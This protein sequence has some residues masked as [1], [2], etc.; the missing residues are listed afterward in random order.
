MSENDMYADDT[1]YK[2]C[3]KCGEEIRG[4]WASRD[5]KYWHP[6]C[7]PHDRPEKTIL[8][9]GVEVNESWVIGE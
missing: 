4:Q 9:N 3:E 2:V 6:E 5:G 8:K 7:Y 1:D